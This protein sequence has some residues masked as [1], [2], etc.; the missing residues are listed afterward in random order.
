MESALGMYGLMSIIG[1][2]SN[3]SR[4]FTV[5]THFSTFNS[6]TTHKPIG[7]G[8]DGLLQAKTPVFTFTA[9]CFGKTTKVDLSSLLSRK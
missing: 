2:P 5:K 8:R 4:F 9:C 6:S 1:E 3:A 7:F